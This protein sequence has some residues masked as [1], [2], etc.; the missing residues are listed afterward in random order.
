[1]SI[2][3]PEACSAFSLS[4]DPFFHLFWI[5]R[6][7]KAEEKGSDGST[8]RVFSDHVDFLKILHSIIFT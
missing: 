3:N 2:L 8:A 4:I 7:P 5:P 1:M 6:Y